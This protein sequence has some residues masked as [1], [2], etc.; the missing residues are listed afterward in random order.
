[1]QQRQNEHLAV[2]QFKKKKTFTSY[3]KSYSIIY[4]LHL[5]KDSVLLPLNKQ[6]EG[7]VFYDAQS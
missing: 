5:L 7:Q 4:L 6:V 1:M 2:N 3:V